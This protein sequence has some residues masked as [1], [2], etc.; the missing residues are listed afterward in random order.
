MFV[1]YDL[2]TVMFVLYDLIT[3]SHIHEQ[4]IFLLYIL[5]PHMIS[6]SYTLW[7]C[8]CFHL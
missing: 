1:L 2:I 7:Q 6:A 5:L 4:Y 8:H 3:V